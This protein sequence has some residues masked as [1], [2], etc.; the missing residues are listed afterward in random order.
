MM[1]FFYASQIGKKSKEKEETLQ[2][3]LTFCRDFCLYVSSNNSA[4]SKIP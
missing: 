4:N 1:S 2:T 3:R